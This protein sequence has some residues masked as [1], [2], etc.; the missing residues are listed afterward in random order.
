MGSISTASH[1]IEF[2]P[3]SFTVITAPS[4]SVLTLTRTFR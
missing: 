1:V 3:T 2:K 4:K